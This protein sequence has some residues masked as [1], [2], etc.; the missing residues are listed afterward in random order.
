MD[1]KEKKSPTT[2]QM[3]KFQ[4]RRVAIRKKI[5]HFRALQVT[6]MP[7]LRAVL[8]DP[9]VLGDS[10]D[11]VAESIRLYL[12][13]ELSSEDR[14]RVCAV[15]VCEVEARIRH[16]DTSEALDDLR[17]CLRT[18]TY[19]NKWRIKNI[20]GQHKNTRARALQHGVDVKVHSAKT[21]YRHSRK[22]LL[23]LN[24]HGSWE[25]TLKELKDDDVRALNE[26][27]LTE[28]EKQKREQRIAAGHRTADDARESV[29][30]QGALGEGRRQL[31]WIWF[32]VSNDENS[33]GMHEGKLS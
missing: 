7:G 11:A 8:K 20:S 29:V 21:R 22:A 15:A 28:H 3:A 4:E 10:P 18:R 19:L 13:S 9:G 1:V 24:G 25:Q 32:T 16:A 33:P 27:A 12:P 6:Y 2:L 23:A 5:Q 30:V 17:R 26:R 14:N 31:S